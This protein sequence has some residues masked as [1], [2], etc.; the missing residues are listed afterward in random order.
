MPIFGLWNKISGLNEPRRMHVA[1]HHFVRNKGCST[2][3]LFEEV[4]EV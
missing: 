1:I 4:L 3:T 2:E